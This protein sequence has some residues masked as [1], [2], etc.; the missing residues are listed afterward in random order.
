MIKVNGIEIQQG[1]YPDGTLLM[2]T[3]LQLTLHPSGIVVDWRYENDAELFTIICLAKHFADRAKRLHLWYIPHARMDR[4]K[5]ETDVFTLKYF[6]EIIN[7]LGFEEV[8][9]MDVHSPVAEALL[10]NLYIAPVDHCIFR[11]MENIGEE[12][13]E[14]FYPDNG[15]AKRYGQMLRRRCCYGVKDRDWETGEIRGLDVV[16]NINLI[17]GKNILI[18]DDI[19]SRGGT[20]YHSAKKLKELGAG[21][22]YLYITHCENTILEGELLKGDLIERVYTT[23][24][25]FTGQHEKITVFEV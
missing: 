10:N 16:G 19:C 7:S 9:A 4:V 5:Y 17:K 6:A 12:N 15:S 11:A 18:I 8:M 14:I 22:V 2:K 3:P 1:H 25:L 20:F 13:L 24:S 21:K 23:D